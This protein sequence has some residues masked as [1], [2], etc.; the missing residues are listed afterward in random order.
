MIKNSVNYSNFFP[1]ISTA[2]CTLDGLMGF[3]IKMVKTMVMQAWQYKNLRCF[4]G[5][6]L[7]FVILVL[8]VLVL[9]GLILPTRGMLLVLSVLI[10]NLHHNVFTL[11]IVPMMSS[12]EKRST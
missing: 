9:I 6:L 3:N 11:W 1:G 5:L 7:H 12:L 2:H 8:P 4:S 10:D